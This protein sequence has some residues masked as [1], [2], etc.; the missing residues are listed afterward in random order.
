MQHTQSATARSRG[1][2]GSG[3]RSSV[4]TSRP[5]TT[6]FTP[7]TRGASTSKPRELARSSKSRRSRSPTRAANG[8]TTAPGSI[9]CSS[10]GSSR[11]ARASTPP[12]RRGST[13]WKSTPSEILFDRAG[14]TVPLKVVAH[15]ADGTAEDVTCISRFR[16]NDESVAEIDEDGVVTAQG[17]GDTH[18]VAFYDNGVAVTQ[19]LRPVSDRVGANYPSVSVPTK[20][21]EL[22]VAKLKKLGIVPSELCDDAEFLRRVSLDLTG[23]LPTP[24]RDRGIPRRQLAR[25]THR[26]DRRPPRAAD[27][28]GLLGRR[29]LC[30]LT[31]ANPRLFNGQPIQTDATRPLVRLAGAPRSRERPYDKIV[32]GIVLGASRKPGESYDDFIKQES[33]YHRDQDPADFS[34]RETMPYFWRRRSVNTPDEKALNFSYAFLGVRLECA[35]CHKHP[36]DQWTQDD[37]KQFT[38]FFQPIRFGITPESRKRRRRLREELGLN[39]MMG[40]E[41]QRETAKLVKAGK[42]IP[43][44]GSLRRQDRRAGGSA[45][46]QEGPG[47]S[48]QRTRRHAETAR[49]RSGRP[50]GSRRPARALDG[51]ASFQNEPLLR[52][53]VREPGLGERLRAWDREPDRRHE[54]R[55]AP[56]KPRAAGLP[57][58]RLHRAGST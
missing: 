21:D 6:H 30:D 32:A 42:A 45:W 7:R 34:V 16:T 9:G 44:P 28:C 3:S 48:R 46:R 26:Q 51:L 10:A 29:S 13:A 4:T 58:R 47:P 15:W 14:K 52:P 50:R 49:R 25:E 56:L 37:F 24:R 35:Q 20:I 2:A 27:L 53:R 12:P 8:W 38:A 36:F 39:K 54:P 1:V 33:A 18:V 43:L 17:V 19:V 55:Q 31:G 5:T 22:V 57:R 11:G 23:T 41:L 40:G